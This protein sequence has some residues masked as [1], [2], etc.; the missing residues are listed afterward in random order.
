MNSFF[1]T[2]FL[3]VTGGFLPAI[4]WLWFWLKEDSKKPEPAQYILQAFLI[5][6]LT[7]V[8]AFFLERP[9]LLVFGELKNTYLVFDG[10]LDLAAVPVIIA[11]SGL[12]LSW[13][14]IEEVL[15]YLA[16]R[17]TVFERPVFDEPIDAMVYLI[18]VALGFAAVENSLFLFDTLSKDDGQI[19]FLLTGHL[20]FLGATVVHV[21]CSAIVGG[22]VALSFYKSAAQKTL[23]AGIGLILAIVL[24]AFFNFFIINN[25][26]R[27]VL[28]VLTALWIAAILVILLFEKVKRVTK[29]NIQ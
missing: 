12:I 13:S 19:F 16:A 28:T 26:G 21:V 15:K 5:G 24:H 11:Q 2:A 3:V 22:A 23:Y 9:L 14:A 29:F 6:G 18:T 8:A 27:D 1:V 25:E 4:V 7:V 17:F 10:R 20:R